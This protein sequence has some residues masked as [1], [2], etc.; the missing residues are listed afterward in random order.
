VALTRD[1]KLFRGGAGGVGAAW[2]AGVAQ[3]YYV[4]E[5]EPRAGFREIVEHFGLSFSTKASPGPRAVME[6]GGRGGGDR[7]AGCPGLSAPRVLVC[8]HVRSCG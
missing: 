2:A 4:A 5:A 7:L 1:S 6:G 3:C 8:A